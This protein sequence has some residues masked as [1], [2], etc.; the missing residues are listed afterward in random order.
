MTAYSRATSK[1]ASS[2]ATGW[3]PPTYGRLRDGPFTANFNALN[4]TPDEQV[5]MDNILNKIFKLHSRSHVRLC[6][7]VCVCAYII[8]AC[9]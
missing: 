2:I 1:T 8:P 3:T 4:L 5:A 6:V 7:C 9:C